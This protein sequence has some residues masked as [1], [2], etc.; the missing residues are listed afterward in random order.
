MV[1]I[2]GIEQ[3][4]HQSY[5]R[6]IKPSTDAGTTGFGADLENAIADKAAAENAEAPIRYVQAGSGKKVFLDQNALISIAHAPTGESANVYKAEGYSDSNPLY[7]VKGT[8]SSGNLYEQAI[9]VSKV[10]PK[11]CSYIALLALSAHTGNTD[12]LTLSVMRDQAE[13]AGYHEKTDYLTAAYDRMDDLKRLKQWDSYFRYDSW[14]NDILDYL[15]S[16][17]S[18]I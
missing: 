4:N 10:D 7:L 2:N 16:N 14:I 1:N 11:N 3:N 13:N 18:L 6:S 9:D 12:F 5:S 17:D 8:D 15:R